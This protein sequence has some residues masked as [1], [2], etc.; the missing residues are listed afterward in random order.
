MRAPPGPRCFS[1]RRSRLLLPAH[2][3]EMSDKSVCVAMTQAMLI[4][5]YLDHAH[6][7]LVSVRSQD[8]EPMRDGVTI[9]LFD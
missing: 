7:R 9:L 6:M 5:Q 8:L 1:P 3:P 2:R 4:L